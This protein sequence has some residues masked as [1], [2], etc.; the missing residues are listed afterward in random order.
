VDRSQ[1]QP[2]SA[3]R[4]TDVTKTAGI[5]FR[6][7]N[8]ASGRFYL[9][10]TVG[11]GCAFLDYNNDGKPDLFLVN[12]SR[13][14][15]YPDKGPFF[16]ALYRNNGDRTFTDVTKSSGLAVDCYGMG[17]AIA[18]YD[19]DGFED[20][21]LTA[22]GPSH[23]FHNNGDGTFADVTRKAGVGGRRW[24]TSAAW[25]DYDR[26]G[27]LDLFV[28]NYCQWSPETNQSCSDSSGRKRICGPTYYRGAP[29]TLY[30][31]NGDG[32]FSDVTKKAG[33]FETAGK[34]LGVVVWDY[35]D[36]GW[37]DL[38]IAKDRE[39]NLLFRNNHDGTF[40]ERG[41]EAGIA[42][43]TQGKSRAGMGIDTADTLDDG[44]ESILIGNFA[45]QGLAQFQTD[46]QGHFTDV[47][48]QTGLYEPSLP[49]LTFGVAFIDYDG[50]GFKDIVTANG[51]TELSA[52]GDAMRLQA[53]HNEGSGKFREVGA[54]LGPAFTEKR[55]WRGLA[56]GDF[57]GDG[58]PDLLVSTCGGKP[59]LLR[60]EGGNRRHWLQVKAMAIGQN[61]EG[62][63]TK[64]TVM[65]QGRRQIG[66]IRSGS[67]YCSQN[68]L[69]AF[70]GLGS[71]AQ[72][73]AVELRFPDGTRQVVPNVKTNQVIVVQEGKGLVAPG[74]PGTEAR[75]YP[76]L[77]RQH[78]GANSGKHPG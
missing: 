53:F 70:F 77:R 29:S 1:G 32:T 36:D 30:R 35:N 49:F 74:P 47:A 69:V 19:G 10:E 42:Y 28:C 57:D 46:G 8:G 5:R 38:V 17:V 45:R 62:I 20:L 34:A 58:D 52:A 37:P 11:S 40:T 23:L 15:G 33:L 66:W 78:E 43:S 13:L 67:S 76:P 63:G 59:A 22:L 9:P 48:D 14:P 75:L 68:E 26:K 54:E 64:V 3:V 12:S 61:R 51:H 50:D 31:N 16:P 21:Y 44:R 55:V 71:A 6:H 41:V 72:A 73:E 24:G 25:L 65:A 60:N 18:D 27:R 2:A 56:I 39:P 4:F 7:T